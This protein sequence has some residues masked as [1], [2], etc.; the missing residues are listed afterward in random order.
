MALCRAL[1]GSSWWFMSWLVVI[2]SD[3]CHGSWWFN[4]MVCGGSWW[5]NVMVRGGS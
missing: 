4:V 5:F 3:S 2:S 1:S